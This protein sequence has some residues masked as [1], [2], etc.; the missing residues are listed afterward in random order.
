MSQALVLTPQR[1]TQ[2]SKEHILPPAVDGLYRPVESVASYIRF[3]RERETG[4]SKAGEAVKK[5]EL[6]NQL[7]QIKLQ[8]LAGQLVE[9]DRVR[10][11]WFHEARRVRD[12]LLNLPSRLSGIFAAENQQEKIYEHFSREIYNVL[13]ALSKPQ[14]SQSATVD[15]PVEEFQRPEPSPNETGTMSEAGDHYMLPKAELPEDRFPTGD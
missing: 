15:V 10:A 2:L 1:V 12:A 5:L 4:R 11:D 9:V 7:R 14:V 8:K 6:E 13:E 3:L